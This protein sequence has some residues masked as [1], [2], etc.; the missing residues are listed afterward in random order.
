MDKWRKQFFAAEMK[1]HS[2]AD[3][4]QLCFSMKAEEPELHLLLPLFR[5]QEVG[6]ILTKKPQM[7]QN[8][9][10]SIRNQPRRS[11]DYTGLSSLP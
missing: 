1:V 3:D 5:V 2:C 11:H 6:R 7:Y 9:T 10:V 4:A 8:A